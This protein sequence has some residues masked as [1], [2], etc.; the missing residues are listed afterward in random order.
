MPTTT[1][2]DASEDERLL[3]VAQKQVH[4]GAARE[5]KDH[6]LFQDL[7][8]ESDETPAP[9]RRQ[10]VRAL[11]GETRR[12]FLVGEAREAADV[13]LGQHDSTSPLL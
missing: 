9:R 11:G 4:P 13:Q 12:R 2:T 7:G 10:L 8:G 6:R 5:E 3:A 1:R